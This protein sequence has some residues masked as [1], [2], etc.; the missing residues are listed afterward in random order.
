MWI[1]VL[2]VLL[3][4]L[5]FLLRPKGSFSA[6]ETHRRGRIEF[7]SKGMDAGFSLAEINLLWSA[8]VRADLPNPPVIYGSV[9]ELDKAIN[10]IAGE[11]KFSDRKGLEPETVI[12]KKLFNY[13][14]KIEMSR[15]KYKSGL[16]TT[17]DIA[18]GQRLTIRSGGAGIYTSKIIDNEQAYMTISIPVGDPLPPGFS[19]R[20]GRIN[21]YFWRK[22]DAGYFFQTK[23]IE[24]YYDRKGQHFRINHSDNILR[25]QKRKSVRAPAKIPARMYPLKTLDDANL[26]MESAS[27]LSCIILDISEDGAALRIGGKG[28]KGQPFKLQFKIRNEILVVSGVVKRV[29]YKQK[30]DESVLH[31]EFIPP[32]ENIRMA[33][34]SYVFDIDRTRAAKGN[35]S[36]QDGVLSVISGLNPEADESERE[37]ELLPI[38]ENEEN[39]EELEEI[40][41]EEDSEDA[42]EAGIE[43]LE[44]VD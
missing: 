38:Q 22:D 19:W 44:S 26:W 30:E 18:V 21:V 32:P 35:E 4:I 13:R 10:Q 17:R 43:E 28:R 34:L 27:G 9:E 3:I 31:V 24:R 11:K 14:K 2:A 37:G 12:L 6:S 29:T 8:A 16:K 23:L 1:A 41:P 33:I 40:L 15:P 20:Q 42:E 25:S 36:D 5:V 7:Y 39:E